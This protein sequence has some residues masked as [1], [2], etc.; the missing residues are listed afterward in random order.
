V[1]GKDRPIPAKKTKTFFWKREKVKNR[2][3][4]KTSTSLLEVGITQHFSLLSVGSMNEVDRERSEHEVALRKEEMRYNMMV[5]KARHNLAKDV[6]VFFLCLVGCVVSVGV[7]FYTP[8]NRAYTEVMVVSA[9]TFGFLFALGT[10]YIP[11]A[12]FMRRENF[13]G[14]RRELW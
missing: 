8:D 4:K 13:S 3:E 9:A 11:G 1:K 2:N 7:I 14:H 5:N 6:I 12:L 10:I